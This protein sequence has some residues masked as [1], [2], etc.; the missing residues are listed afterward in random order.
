MGPYVPEHRTSVAQRATSNP[1]YLCAA[2]RLNTKEDCA[3]LAFHPY[4]EMLH[5]E[6][7]WI[8]LHKCSTLKADDAKA[9]AGL[10]GAEDRRGMKA[11]RGLLKPE[12]H[13]LHSAGE[14]RLPIHTVPF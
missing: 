5:D 12:H 4:T 14:L 10:A 3:Y 6:Q 11:L 1:A 13:P 2:K 8:S 7:V 9:N